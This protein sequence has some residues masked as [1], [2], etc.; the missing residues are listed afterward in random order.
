MLFRDYGS[1]ARVPQKG[2][3]ISLIEK[4]FNIEDPKQK[5]LTEVTFISYFVPGISHPI[6]VL[7]GEHGAGKT[8][9]EKVIKRLVDPSTIDVADIVNCDRTLEL[10]LEQNLVIPFDNLS[11]LSP[12][13]SDRFCRTVTGYTVTRRFLFKDDAL[14]TRKINRCIILGGI[15]SVAKNPGILDR[16][17]LVELKRIPEEDRNYD[18]ELFKMLDD[19]APYIT[20]AI[21]DIVSSALRIFKG[22]KDD[23]RF[24]R[25]KDFGKIGFAIAES[26]GGKGEE[27]L[28]ALKENRDILAE[29]IREANV[30]AVPIISYLKTLE[31]P[32]DEKAA[33][34]FDE[35][36]AFACEKYNSHI[37]KKLPQRANVF[38]RDVKPL[39]DNIKSE[40]FVFDFYRDQNSRYFKVKKVE[41]KAAV[42]DHSVKN[43]ETAST[44][45]I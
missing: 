23:A 14:R 19:E 20:G 42:K 15:N 5:L 9:D 35:F 11:S 39:L 28:E 45:G 40:G 22:V 38:S 26:M 21:F 29:E 13:E 34:F 12:E 37:T 31:L 17:V 36:Y 16:S 7:S 1:A 18:V 41:E 2:G 10:V 24:G 32:L 33:D 3:N 25:L 30:L 6:L 4:Y 27:F 43:S 44:S 8:T